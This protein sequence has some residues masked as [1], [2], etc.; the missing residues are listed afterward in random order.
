MSEDE[1][2]QSLRHAACGMRHAAC[3]MRHAAEGR[4]P[5]HDSVDLSPFIETEVGPSAGPACQLADRGD[6]AADVLAPTDEPVT[7]SLAG[8]VVALRDSLRQADAL[9]LPRAQTLDILELGPLGGL[10]AR[11]RS[12]LA[13]PPPAATAEFTIGALVKDMALLA[14]ASN[15]PLRSA[16]GLMAAT[17]AGQQGDIAVAAAIPAVDDAV[18]EPLRAYIRGHATGNPHTS[19]THSYPP[20]TSRAS[21]TVPSPPGA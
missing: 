16:A 1:T 21:E 6:A 19:A 13:G 4:Q 9:G 5:D 2:I 8:S 18:L 10:V 17:P 15:T 20:P 11:K 7:F 12:W 3:G 14:A